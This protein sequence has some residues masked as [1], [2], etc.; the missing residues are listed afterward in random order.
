MN[1]ED[2]NKTVARHSDSG[3]SSD[4]GENKILQKS[5]AE[6]VERAVVQAE[7]PQKRG[8]GRPLNARNK[9]MEA[10]AE[11]QE[12]Q[13]G[14]TVGELLTHTLFDGFGGHTAAG[15][16]PGRFMEDRARVMAQRLGIPIGEAMKHCLAMAGDLMPYVHQKLPVA[17]EA[18]V[19]GIMLAVV[20]TDG[21]FASPTGRGG[22]DLRPAQARQG[23]AIEGDFEVKSDG[24]SRT[25]EE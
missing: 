14:M 2:N 18:N 19:K 13:F 5:P 20:G 10:L 12:Q 8:P 6:A 11:L 23:G 1:T 21:G 15:G 25:S 22:L 24:N 7:Q 17:L 9:R 4:A 16:E 3:T